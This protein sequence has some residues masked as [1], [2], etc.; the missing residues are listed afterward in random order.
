MQNITAVFLPRL[1]NQLLRKFCAA[2]GYGWDYPDS[3]YRDVP[4]CFPEVLCLRLLL[5]VLTS[6]HFALNP[7][8]ADSLLVG[9]AF[10]CSCLTITASG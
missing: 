3:E 5:M 8:G 10:M 6:S 7:A 4:L 1:E 9:I 2:A